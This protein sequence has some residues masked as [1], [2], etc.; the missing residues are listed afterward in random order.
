MGFNLTE[1]LLNNIF[2]FVSYWKEKCVVGEI[3]LKPTIQFGLTMKLVRLIK[4]C[5]NKSIVRSMYLNIC[6][7]IILCRLI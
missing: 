2:D 1:Q 6:L 4:M 5:L 3:S 7:I